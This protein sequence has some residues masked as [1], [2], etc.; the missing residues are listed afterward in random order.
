[1]KQK[2][3]ETAKSGKDLVTEICETVP[4]EGEAAFWWLGQLG[5]AVKLGAVTFYIDAFLADHPRRRI[6]P[7]LN[8]AEIINGSIWCGN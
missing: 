1:M 3:M 4:G 6:P 2:Y 7:L 5:Y 8:P